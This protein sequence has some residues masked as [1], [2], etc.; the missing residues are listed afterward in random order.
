MARLGRHAPGNPESGT[1]E[2]IIR[3]FSFLLLSML[4][5]QN[6]LVTGF[7]RNGDTGAPVAYA[8]VLVLNTQTGAI[9]DTTGRFILPSNVSPPS[10]SCSRVLDLKRPIFRFRKTTGFP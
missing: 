8:N 2:T 6:T 1:P 3:I 5:A 7:V 10:V 9:T 4:P